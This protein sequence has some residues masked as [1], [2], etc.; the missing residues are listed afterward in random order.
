[1]AEENEKHLARGGDDENLEEQE[2]DDKVWCVNPIGEGQKIWVIHQAA[3]RFIRKDIA[4]Q[5]KKNIKELEI[6]DVDELIA[7]V[8]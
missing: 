6:V 8:E 1:M 4:Q 2:I 5:M 7:K 3:S